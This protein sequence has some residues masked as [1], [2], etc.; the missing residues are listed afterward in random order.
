MERQLREGGGI[1]E[2]VPREEAFIGG[3]K[4]AVKKVTKAVKNVAKSPVGK[5]AMLYFGG[6]LLQ[7]NQLFGNPFTGRITDFITQGSGGILDSLKLAKGKQLTGAQKAMNALK[8]GGMT[9]GI[10]G[11]LAAAEQ[12]DEE[13]IE[14]TTNVDSL[15]KYLTSSYTNLGYDP[16]EIPALVERDVSEYT[17]DTAR[18]NY[19][20]GGRTNFNRGALGQKFRQYLE[21]TPATQQTQTAAPA[22]QPAAQPAAS[23][24]FDLS[25]YGQGVDLSGGIEDSRSIALSNLADLGYDTSRFMDTSSPPPMSSGP[26]MVGPGGMMPNMTFKDQETLAKLMNPQIGSLETDLISVL[27]EAKDIGRNYT[28]DQALKLNEEDIFEIS[29]LYNKKNKLG[30]YAPKQSS[31]YTGPTDFTMVGGVAVPKAEGGRV[32]YAEGT[33]EGIKSIKPKKKPSAGKRIL[34]LFDQNKQAAYNTLGPRNMFERMAK[35]A[36][37]AYKN[38]EISKKEFNRMIMP[39]FG[40]GGEMLTSKIDEERR[41]LDDVSMGKGFESGGRVEYAMGSPEDNAIKAA[42]I[43]DLPLNQNKAGV[44]ELDLRETGG[45]IPPVGVKEKADDIPAMLSNNEFVF[46]ADAVRGMGDG[47]VNVGAQRMYDMMKKLENGGR[48]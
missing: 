4:K 8:V 42:G 45:F 31:T 25:K 34:D 33:E 18:G 46:T 48:V 32:G 15:R 38:G 16:D 47:N 23:Q 44:T 24:S 6:N 36:V 3:L 22:P 26:Q 10:T 20:V 19:S 9:A 11:L 37:E 13:A 21:R 39:F 7:G 30:P 43:M 12:G 29:D 2:V 28:I 40:K 14:A 17:K 35:S 1:M 27:R 41:Y 5:A